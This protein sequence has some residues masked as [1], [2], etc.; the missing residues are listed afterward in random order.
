MR[1]RSRWGDF[2]FTLPIYGDTLDPLVKAYP[3]LEEQKQL[4]FSFVSSVSLLL[5]EQTSCE[6]L[7]KLRHLVEKNPGGTSLQW[8]FWGPSKGI[9]ESPASK[10]T[11]LY[12]EKVAAEIRTLYLQTPEE[13][14][15]GDRTYPYRYFLEKDYK[16][17]LRERALP[18]ISSVLYS[19]YGEFPSLFWEEFSKVSS[20]I[21]IKMRY[22]FDFS[23]D[24]MENFNGVL[25]LLEVYRK[26]KFTSESSL[27]KQLQRLGLGFL[28]GGS[29]G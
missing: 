23:Q 29:H 5:S 24:F 1:T 2:G 9:G 6:E 28:L 21:D 14:S 8:V 11:F 7:T 18:I 16:K 26:N 10:T 20:Y 17:A 3:E 4:F 15:L 12:N 25:M 27:G 22:C 13:H 19:I